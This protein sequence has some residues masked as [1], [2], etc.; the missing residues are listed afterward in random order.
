[1]RR[2]AQL[3]ARLSPFPVADED[4]AERRARALALR[5]A[6]DDEVRALRR[7]H[8]HPRRRAPAGLVAAFLALRDHAFEAARERRGLQRGAVLRRMHE[9]DARSRQQALREIAAAIP[10]RRPG[11][12]DAGEIRHVEAVEDD[13][14]ALVGGGNLALRLQLGAILKRAERRLA[15]AVERD[16]LAVEDHSVDRLLA[17]LCGELRELRRELEP[18]ARAQLDA[19]LV[20]EREDAIAVELGLPHPVGTIERRV[21]RFGEH[22]RELRRHRHDL[23]RRDELRGAHLDARAA[24]LSSSTAIAERTERFRVVT[25][26]GAAKRS[27]CFSRSH[28]FASLVR[29]SANDPLSFSPRSRKLSLPLASPSLTSRSAA[30]RSWNHVAPPSSGE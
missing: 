6:A 4:R 5:V 19:V 21:T 17:E 13:R 29:T 10:V 27:L 2:V 14:R 20:D 8:L 16:E 30:S 25:S 12:I 3:A 15:G 24:T 11:E 7:L 9:L 26:T 23:A 22:R 28:C 18:A 1:M